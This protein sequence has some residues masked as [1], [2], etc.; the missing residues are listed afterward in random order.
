MSQQVDKVQMNE[1]SE[2]MEID[3]LELFYYFRSK[4]LIILIGFFAGALLAGSITHFLITPKYSATS[5]VYMVSASN[6]SVV[7]LTDLNIGQSLSADYEQ[8]I[9]T[10]PIYEAVIKEL[11]LP[12]TYEQLLSIV[13]ISVV[14]DTRILTITTESTSPKEAMDVSNA[15]ADKAVSELPELMDTSEPNIAEEAVMPK[16]PSSPS[17]AKNTVFGAALGMIL[18]LGVLTVLF[19]TDDTFK[20][21]EDVEKAFGI[22]PLTIIPESDVAAISDQKEKEDRAKWK[23]A[24]R[25]KAEA[26]GE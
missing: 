18:V 14:T 21:A 4:L 2:E 1:T 20:S 5:K 10:R 24:R 19:M 3:L 8:L 16:R 25:K 15:L 11:E 26:K 13:T 6:D 22:M 17:L 23:K 9:Q 12:Y 7:D